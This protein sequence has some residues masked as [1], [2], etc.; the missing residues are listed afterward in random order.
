MEKKNATT[1]T[2][3]TLS[4]ENARE[5]AK[6][7]KTEISQFLCLFTIAGQGALHTRFS[8][9]LSTFKKPS[10]SLQQKKRPLWNKA[11]LSFGQQ[12][13]LQVYV[14]RASQPLLNAFLLWKRLRC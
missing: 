11:S 3:F 13:S 8:C 4:S 10:P 12:Q 9:Q 7:I 5:V 6:S 1:W 2:G 14:A